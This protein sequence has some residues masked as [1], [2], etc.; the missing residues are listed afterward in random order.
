MANKLANIARMTCATTGT[1]TLTLGVAVVNPSEG[2]FNT[3]ADAGIVDGDIISYG[4]EDTNGNRETGHGTYTASGTTLSRDVIESSTNG[5]AKIDLSG[6]A[7][8][9]ITALRSAFNV[10]IS[11]MDYGA[12]GDGVTDDT[13]AVNAALARILAIAAVQPNPAGKAQAAACPFLDLQGRDYYITSSLDATDIRVRAWGIKNG[14]I[15]AG[16]NGGVVLDLTMSRFCH[17]YDVKIVSADG[18][19][20]DVGILVGRDNSGA[21]A[22]VHYFENVHVYGTF[23]LACLFNYASEDLTALACSFYNRDTATDSYVVVLDGANHLGI[24]SAFNTVPTDS[25]ASFND[26]HFIRGDFRKDGGPVIYMTKTASHHFDN[27]YATTPDDA[28]FVIDTTSTRSNSDITIDAHLETT[29][30]LRCVRFDGDASQTIVGFRFREYLS[31]AS[32]EVFK[33]GTGVTGLTLRDVDI[34]ISGFSAAPANNVFNTAS[35]ITVKGGRI[36][37]GTSTYDNTASLAAV[38]AYI[39][40]NLTS[41]L[42]LGTALAVADGGTGSTTAAA[43]R[44]ALGLQLV[45]YQE[46][47]GSGTWTKPT[48]VTPQMVYVELYGGGGGGGGGARVASG[49]QAS[50]GGGGG[51]ASAR[52]NWFK[53]SDLSATETVTIGAGGPFGAGSTSDGVAGSNGTAGGNS[54]FGSRLTAF[55]GGRGAGGQVAGNSGGG[56]GA[57]CYTVGGDATTGTGGA[58]GTIGG[59]AGG[60]GTNGTNNANNS[61]SGGGSG[62]AGGLNAG[63]GALGGW[64][65]TSGGSG[66]GGGGGGIATGPT[67]F[68]GGQ[69]GRVPESGALAGGAVG[70]NQ[71]T[72]PPVPI[73]GGAGGGPGGGANTAGAGGAGRD[74]AVRGGGGGGGGS[75]IGGNGGAGGS[76]GAGLCRVWTFT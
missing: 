54:T 39:A 4:I 42:K 32:Q 16:M 24:T 9:F 76:G 10:D 60:S 38:E 2:R 40:N 21:V 68:A 56:G 11:P 52:A 23:A 70:G 33:T 31:F 50:G 7:E 15:L 29:G 5:G 25:L 8:V 22:D 35:A 3:F 1:G 30:L 55:G 58:A 73:T 57:S 51:G 64:V 49:T 36:Y 17:M 67:H 72:N 43:A 62:G 74:G 12:V 34:D 14:R 37:I 41:R 53:A 45:D 61:G 69:G 63:A 75:A 47:T 71:G 26:A 28:I 20:P 44:T 27:C 18:F 66:G 13:A 46:F 48:A 65:S 59:A 19:T 6:N